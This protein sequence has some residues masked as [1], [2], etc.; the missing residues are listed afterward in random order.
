M[1]TVALLAHVESFL[2]KTSAIPDFCVQ[3]S[4]IS[5][6]AAD[7]LVGQEWKQARAPPSMM[8]IYVL[9]ATQ[10]WWVVPYNA[11]KMALPPRLAT[12][13]LHHGFKKQ[14]VLNSSCAD[15]R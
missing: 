3:R 2:W 5:A 8:G 14:S 9:S 11:A 10:T 1:S 6:G 7:F 4:P 13:S 12:W 15:R